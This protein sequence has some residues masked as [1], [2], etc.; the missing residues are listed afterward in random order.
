MITMGSDTF[1]DVLRANVLGIE[2]IDTPIYRTFRISHLRSALTERHLAL[3]KPDLWED[4]FEN[5][6]EKCLIQYSNVK[7]FRQVALAALRMPVYAQ[8]W[9]LSEES[10]A[11]WRIYSAVIKD[12]ETTRNTACGAEGVKVQTTAR[13]L[14]TALWNASTIEPQQSCFLGLVEYMPRQEALRHVI[15]AVHTSREKVWAD[16]R[17]HARSLLVKREPF[18]H[19]REVRLIYVD[20][21]NEAPRESIHYIPIDPNELFDAIVLDPRLGTNDTQDRVAEFK[22][23]G[24]PGPIAKSELYQP[25]FFVLAV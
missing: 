8:C 20:L 21:R 16:G 10:D 23:L 2:N 11:L 3:V 13:K 1:Q 22:Q 17:G 9:S 6:I 12:P 15:N 5:L 14:V 4:P 18:S 7:P 19:E 24:Y 25:S